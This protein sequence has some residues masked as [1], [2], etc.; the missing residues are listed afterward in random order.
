MPEPRQPKEAIADAEVI[1]L[2]IPWSRG[3][4]A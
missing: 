2:A 3:S 1:V 4:A